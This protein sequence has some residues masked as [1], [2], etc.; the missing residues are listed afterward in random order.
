MKTFQSMQKP[1][2][3][4]VRLVLFLFCLLL[5]SCSTVPEKADL[6]RPTPADCLPFFH[7]RDGW[8]GGDGAYS[9]G[10]NDGRVLWLF[11]DT[12]VSD[13][14]GRQ[15]RTDMKVVLGTTLAVSTCSADSGFQIRHY[16]KRKNGEFVSS[17][18]EKEWL[19][20]QDPFLVDHVLYIPLLSIKANPEMPGPFK[21]EIAG[22]KLARIMSFEEANPNRWNVEYL[23]LTPGIPKEILAFA[24]TA[25]AFRN[26]VYFYPL[27]G[28]TRNGKSV[29][30]NILARIPVGKLDDPARAIEYLTRS[31]RWERDPDPANVRVVL[32]AAVSELSIRY[33][34]GIGKWIAV[35][36]SVRNNGDRMLYQTADAPEG[37]WSEPKP[38]IA[39]IPEVDRNSSRYDRNNFCYAGKEHP[40]FAG[41]GTLVVT[42]V[43]NSHE[44]LEKR[45][46]FIRRN[47]FLYRPVVN[48][49]RIS[50]EGMQMK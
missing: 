13:E 29:L 5:L 12:F 36:L 44:D 4:A 38:L 42:Y 11:G 32:D 49:V 20:P 50:D 8:Y 25:V 23:D 19:W 28:A 7:D 41:N 17:F 27:Y 47:L 40:E 34:P 46:S 15:D 6:L 21:F 22:H 48:R 39:S 16:L 33:H 26:Y 2:H 1:T 45:T 43:C 31:G 37:P 30:G 10:L 14:E 18:E 24:T 3:T 9:I 35:Y